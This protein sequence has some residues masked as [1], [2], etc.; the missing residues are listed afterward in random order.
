VS[1]LSFPK[2]LKLR[3]AAIFLVCLLTGCAAITPPPPGEKIVRGVVYARR[4]TGPEHLDIYLP[5]G[6]G[7]FP[8]VIWFHSGG[9]NWRSSGPPVRVQCFSHLVTTA[10]SIPCSVDPLKRRDKLSLGGL[11]RLV[12]FDLPNNNGERRSSAC[13]G[14]D[15]NRPTGSFHDRAFKICV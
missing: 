12:D 10:F 6:S 8:V 2:A 1:T 9:W 7:P 4:S 14:V 5:A 13:N 11:R 15:V 3:R